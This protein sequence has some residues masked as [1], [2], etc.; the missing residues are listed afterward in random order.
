MSTVLSI[1]ASP[2][3]VSSTYALLT[4]V[5]RRVLGAGHTVQTL[6]VRDLPPAAL[7]AAD[8]SDPA[9]IDAIW[10]VQQ[11]DAIIVATPV[12]QA[13]YSGLLKIFLDLLPQFAFRGKAVLPLATGGSPA[14]VLA[15]DYALRPV[16]S[17]LGA[18]HI[19]QGWFVPATHIRQWGD[20][21][22]LI[23]PSSLAPV[24]QVTDE[25][26]TTVARLA[27]PSAI[28][29]RVDGSNSAR[30]SPI[31]GTPD[32]QVERV[33]VGDPR[34]A[35]LLADLVVEYGTRYGR[36]SAHTQLTEVPATD[37]TEPNGVFL[38]LQENGETVAGGALRRYDPLTA[39]VKR[40]WTSHRHRRRG[41]ARRVMAELEA[42]ATELGYQRI[43]LTTGPRQPEARNLYLAAGYTPRFDPAADPETI[44]PLA[45]AKELV[46]G[47]GLAQW[48]QPA[49]AFLRGADSEETH[50]RR[51][52]QQPL[53]VPSLED[54]RQVHTKLV[55]GVSR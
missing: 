2:S 12:Y 45:F 39:E 23:D 50:R 19:G 42:A 30:V 21:G 24:A 4:H 43:H 36:P 41:L 17:Q 40:V 29:A 8:T 3:Q 28:P 13:A 1:S 14:H 37:F 15:V 22:V 35:P 27:G 32:L 11:A 53:S 31:A 44:G 34:L 38:I 48:Q 18:A 47:A 20:G 51:V 52:Y 33:G 46:P 5:N 54:R 25:F 7:V 9:I 16:L 55:N 10:A 6:Q 26:L 49:A